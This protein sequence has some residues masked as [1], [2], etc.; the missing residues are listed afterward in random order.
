MNKNAPCLAVAEDLNEAVDSVILLSTI[1]EPVRL[2]IDAMN[3]QNL[4]L[5]RKG[6]KLEVIDKHLVSDNPI[7]RRC[8]DGRRYGALRLGNNGFSPE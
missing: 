7:R 2:D 6:A 1:S 4:R 3:E 8:L 5:K